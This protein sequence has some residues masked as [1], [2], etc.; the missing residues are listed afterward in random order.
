M[1]KPAQ[2][3]QFL[4]QTPAFEQQL[5]DDGI[6]LF[7]YWLACDQAQQEKRFAERQAD[8][9]KGWKLSPIDLEARTR[10]RAYTEATMLLFMN[11]VLLG[12][13]Y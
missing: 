10:Y 13:G 6:L 9:L 4:E 11:A 3:E 2:V 1:T 5:V 12:P 7:K 8:P